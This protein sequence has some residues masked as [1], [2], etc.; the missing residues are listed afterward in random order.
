MTARRCI[1]CAF[2]LSSLYAASRRGRTDRSNR[3]AQPC[4]PKGEQGF[5]F[6]NP[7][8]QSLIPSLRALPRAAWFLFVGTFLNRFGAFVIPFLVIYMRQRGFT[9]REAAAA[10][11]AYGI[12][13]LAA[14][15]L[16]GYLSD[17]I[18]RRKTIALSKFSS[19]TSMF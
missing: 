4:S 19:A 10:L 18:G 7:N 11:G 2:G 14:S 13:H 3:F 16:G 1:A 5:C 12:G 9:D 6:M 15:V 8:S 17:R